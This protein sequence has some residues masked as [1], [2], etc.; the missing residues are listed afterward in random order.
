MLVNFVIS[1][2]KSSRIFSDIFRRFMDDGRIE[3]VVSEAPLPAADIYH[4]HRPQLEQSLKN[5]SVVTVHHDLDDPDP[6]VR[7]D[8]FEISYRQ[9]KSIVCLNSIQKDILQSKGFSNTIVIPHG[10]D[11]ALFKKKVVKDLVYPDRLTLGIVSKRYPRR[12]K[13]EAY[14]YDLLDYLP[15]NKFRFLLVGEG[16][17]EDAH[18]IRSLGYDVELHEWLPYRMFSEV[19]ENIDC[20]LMTSTFEGGPANLPEAVATGTPAICTPVGMV[21]DMISDGINGVILTGNMLQDA[22]TLLELQDSSTGKLTKLISG[23][24]NLMTAPTW[25]EVITQHLALYQF[26]LKGEGSQ[27]EGQLLTV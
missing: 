1:Q 4:Y 6:F 11:D 20:L 24:H 16:R 5:N 23:A 25:S 15:A 22:T 3:V 2:D 10:Y 9:A 8:R 18:Y 26:I 27:K 17:S 13:G 21:S 14:F 12:F 7:W 19:Y